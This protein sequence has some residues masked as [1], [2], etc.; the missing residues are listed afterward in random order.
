MGEFPRG[1]VKLSPSLGDGNRQIVRR[2][3]G[4]NRCH[5]VTFAVSGGRT[6]S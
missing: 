5:C 3:S 4:S 6:G 2:E 1:A